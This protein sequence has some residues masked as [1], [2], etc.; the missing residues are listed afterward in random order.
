MSGSAVPSDEELIRAYR[1]GGRD[2]ADQLLTR[3]K[4]LV[5]KLSRARFIVGGDRDDLIQEGMIGLYKAVRDYDSEKAQ[6]A[7]FSTFAALCIDRQMLR[8]IEASQREK[9]RPLN[10]SLLLADEEWE[11]VIRQMADSPETIVIDQEMNDEKFRALWDLLS[12]MEKKVLS[13]YVSGMDYRE[14]AGA[15]GKPPKSIDN[16][17]Q[18]I[19]KK[20]ASAF[21]KPE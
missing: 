6:S 3:Y 19:R 14:I 5:L 2:A 8:A 13:L 21:R 11:H 17:I 9:N 10:T 7:S 16:A 1:A 12:P 20:S 18:R 4:P 15:L